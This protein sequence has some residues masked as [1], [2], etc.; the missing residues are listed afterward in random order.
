M[1]K[2]IHLSASPTAL[3][4]LPPGLPLRPKLLPGLGRAVGRLVCREGA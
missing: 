4:P 3:A 1:C 2:A